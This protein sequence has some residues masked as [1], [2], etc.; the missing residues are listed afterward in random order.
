ME[1]SYSYSPCFS[2]PLPQAAPSQPL[3]SLFVACY[4]EC[5]NIVD[6]LCA[7]RD[8]CIE[9]GISYEILLIDDASNDD[10]VQIIR[11]WIHNHPAVPIR[12]VVNSINQGL[13]KNFIAA[14]RMLSGEWYRL[15]C[16][17]NVE[18]KETLMTIFRQIGQAEILLP[19]HT[20]CHGKIWSRKLISRC[21]TWGVNA[22]NGYRIRYYNGLPVTRRKYTEIFC[23]P[24]VGFGFQADFVTQLLDLGLSWLEIGV[25]TRERT[26]GSS[27]ALTMKNF[28]GASVLFK[29]LLMRRLKRL[30]CR[31]KPRYA[32]KVTIQNLPENI[33]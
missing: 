7:V 25:Q 13:A 9:T 26:N 15:I 18:S 3:L 20:H 2:S 33:G 21:F 27:K 16:G 1:T 17:D 19:Y 24:K 22:L 31:T 30:I 4:N 29:R 10:S 12:L 14:A 6:T 32:E 28:F 8:A 11:E 23:H 5:K